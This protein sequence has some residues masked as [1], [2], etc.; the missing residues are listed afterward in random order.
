MADVVQR[1]ADGGVCAGAL[2]HLLCAF[3]A[4]DLMDAGIGIFLAGVDG[5]LHAQ[6]LCKVQTFLHQIQQD[7]V[8]TVSLCHH[9]C[10]QT[11]GAGADDGAVFTSLQAAA[12][13]AV[14]ADGQGLCH[15]G[16]HPAHAVGNLDQHIGRMAEV[17]SHAALHMHTQNMQVVA[18]VGAADGA[19]VAVTTV[20]VR[21]HDHAVANLDAVLVVFR[22]GNDHA[23]QLVADDAGIADQTVGAT[24]C[25][26][27]TAADTGC[28]DLDQGFAGLGF[29][30][31]DLDAGNLPGLSKTDRID[32]RHKIDLLLPTDMLLCEPIITPLGQKCNSFYSFFAR[33]PGC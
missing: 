10:G 29:R 6:R 27:I 30:H 13:D 3:A 28:H 18:A 5:V 22:D 31:G 26:D 15:G 21:V 12:V 33:N 8:C 32:F 7:G 20:Q 14:Q 17:L 16:L 23:G 4:G 9:G 19:G 24:E 1:A 2:H 11:D 25:T